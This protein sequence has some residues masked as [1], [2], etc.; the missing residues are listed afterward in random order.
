MLNALLDT[1][2]SILIY[3]NARTRITGIVS[4]EIEVI[5]GQLTREGQLVWIETGSAQLVELSARVTHFPL[6]TIYLAI[7][8]SI[9]L[10]NSVQSIQLIAWLITLLYIR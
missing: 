10:F 6:I 2:L 8:D 4:T 9:N 1:S 5:A 7:N 3:W